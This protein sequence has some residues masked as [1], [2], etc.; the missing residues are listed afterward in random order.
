M[1]FSNKRGASDLSMASYTDEGTQDADTRADAVAAAALGLSMPMPPLATQQQQQDLT[2][3]NNATNTVPAPTASLADISDG[4]KRL[5]QELDQYIVARGP[6]NVAAAAAAPDPGLSDDAIA[7]LQLA[8]ARK[9]REVCSTSSSC[10][11]GSSIM[12]AVSTRERILSAG[13][14]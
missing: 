4:A 9:L 11:V 1:T 8:T 12:R 13:F 7:D 3:A 5:A 14:F 2:A 10:G 6:T